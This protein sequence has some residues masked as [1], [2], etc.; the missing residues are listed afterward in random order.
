[1]VA[2]SA[3]RARGQVCWL[4]DANTFTV[5]PVVYVKEE[6]KFEGIVYHE[7]CF[8][9]NICNEKIAK[10]SLATSLD[11]KASHKECFTKQFATS[12]GKYGGGHVEKGAKAGVSKLS[13][14]EGMEHDPDKVGIAM[15]VGGG[16]KCA[17]CKKTG[18]PHAC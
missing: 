11:G 2:R 9:C 6:L 1:V 13:R 18:T 3:P 17:A 12:G 14:P 10:V 5:L 8:K 7:T 4:N 15:N 16:K